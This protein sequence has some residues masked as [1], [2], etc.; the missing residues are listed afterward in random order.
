M[1]TR[2]SAGTLACLV[3][4]SVRA[5]AILVAGWAVVNPI[6]EGSFTLTDSE[7]TIPRV[8]NPPLA[9]DLVN[10]P[11]DLRAVAVPTPSNLPDFVRD[12]Q[13]AR[14]LGKALFWD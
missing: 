9:S 8:N 3:T 10:L 6:A 5:L 11:G 13:M 7:V 12:F 4:A 2:H 1:V 14:A